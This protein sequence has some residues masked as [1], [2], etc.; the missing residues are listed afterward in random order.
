MEIGSLLS[1]WL[2]QFSLNRPKKT[3]RFCCK[4]YAM[5]NNSGV[6]VLTESYCSADWA[7]KKIHYIL[8]LLM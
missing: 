5:K 1:Q 2:V 8:P 7:S 6:Y 4:K 3:F